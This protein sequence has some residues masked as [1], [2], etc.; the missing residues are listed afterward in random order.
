MWSEL[1]VYKV[2]D[3]GAMAGIMVAARRA[4]TGDDI[5]LILLLD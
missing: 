3:G 4:A 5:F 2:G 1:S